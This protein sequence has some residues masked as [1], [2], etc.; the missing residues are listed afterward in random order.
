MACI[1]LFI[2]RDPRASSSSLRFLSSLSFV[3]ACLK[4]Q[5]KA[6]NVRSLLLDTLALSNDL[7]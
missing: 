3:F 6:R 1:R 4:R 2:C 5:K 7:E